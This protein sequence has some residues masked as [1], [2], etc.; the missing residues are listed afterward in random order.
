MVEEDTW[1]RLEILKN[2][3]NLVEEFK[4][5]IRKEEV[6]WIEKRKG[7]QKAVEL[8]PEAEEFKRSKLLEKYTTRI[9]FGWDDKKFENKYLKNLERNWARWKGKE[10]GEKE[11]GSSSRVGTLRGEYCYNVVEH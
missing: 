5:E 11:A 10:I 2:V 3:I 7:K 6:Q 8:N 4:K 1:E 9:L